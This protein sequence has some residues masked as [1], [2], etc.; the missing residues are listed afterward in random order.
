MNDVMIELAE[1]H[2]TVKFLKASVWYYVVLGSRRVGNC[3]DV[4]QVEAEEFPD[5]SLKY[6]IAAVPTF[7]FIKV[8]GLQSH[9][10]LHL[11][12]FYH[13]DITSPSCLQGGKVVDRVNGA[14]V[15]ELTKKTAAHS[16]LVAPP[17]PTSQTTPTEVTW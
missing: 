16:E 5:L 6:E 15:P 7:V 11:H 9:L 1:E 8:C 10:E 3:I 13:T 17:P 2:P 12:L 4:P 14:H